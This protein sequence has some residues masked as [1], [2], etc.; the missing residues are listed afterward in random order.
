[1]F[2]DRINQYTCDT[3]GG[4]ITTIDR[5]DGTTPMML[6]CRFTGC[7]GR[8]MSHMYRVQPGLTP[9]HEWF[10]PTGKVARIHREHV[11]RGGLLIRKIGSEDSS[12]QNA[13][14]TPDR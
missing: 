6:A 9:D 4:T 10:K 7:N 13:N 8:M 5:D 1:M 12:D 3:C 11:S 2:K 14:K